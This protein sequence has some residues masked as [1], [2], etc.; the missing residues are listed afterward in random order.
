[1][2]KQPK[3]MFEAIRSGSFSLKP[4]DKELM[5]K[6]R[7]TA[8]TVQDGELLSALKGALSKIDDASGF[9]SDDDSL[10]VDNDDW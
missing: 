1:V 9:S 6:N 5:M 4:V 7:M 3:D 8:Q 2:K 10:D